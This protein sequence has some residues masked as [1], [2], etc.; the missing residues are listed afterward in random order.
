MTRNEKNSTPVIKKV[1]KILASELQENLK[2]KMTKHSKYEY[3]RMFLGG[4][5]GETPFELV[6]HRPIGIT[7]LDR[8]D[9]VMSA[10]TDIAL[11]LAR[12]KD[13]EEGELLKKRL[14]AKK[15]H[16]AAKNLIEIDEDGIV[17]YPIQ[18]EDG[19][20]AKV[21]RNTF[22]ADHRSAAKDQAK[23]LK[24]DFK[25]WQTAD[26]RIR[27]A[28]APVKKTESEILH[29]ILVANGT[30]NAMKEIAFSDF[31]SKKATNDKVEK[32][33]PSLYRT[34]GGPYNEKPQVPVQGFKGKSPGQVKQH[35]SKYI[36]GMLS[37]L[38]V[39]KTDK[40]EGAAFGSESSEE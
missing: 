16:A 30:P 7:D 36:I 4:P 9:W 13:P 24:A 12:E 25:A 32:E 17:Y 6:L 29:E 31:M 22:L 19:V 11:L 1:T 33:F 2:V 8:D 37:L 5:E 40:K 38:V 21:A 27:A 14:V 20:I 18:G 23:K 10:P 28:V 34:C 39:G 15:K 35:F 26:A 3:I